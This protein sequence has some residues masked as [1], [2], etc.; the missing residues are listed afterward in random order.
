[1]K[2]GIFFKTFI[3]FL[4]VGIVPLI[5]FYFLAVISYREFEKFIPQIE[6]LFPE[7]AKRMAEIYQNIGI[8]VILVFLFVFVVIVF[9]SLIYTRSLTNVLNKLIKGSGKIAKGDYDIRV[10]IKTGDELEKLGDAFNKMAQELKAK[11]EALEEEKLSL[12]IKVKARTRELEELAKTLEE[13]VRERTKELQKRV[14]ELEKFQK[15]T[16]GRELRMVE[17]KKEIENLKR[18]LQKYERKEK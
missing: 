3:S 6:P 10:D 2:F 18:E 9:Y 15:L 1:M 4:L 14:E 7:L 16:V 5:L 12:E 13:K 17:L 8:Q 11:T